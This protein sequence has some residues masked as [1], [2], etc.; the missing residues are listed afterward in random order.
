MVI[1]AA[2]LVPRGREPAAGMALIDGQMAGWMK[3]T[4]GAR[5]RFDV[6]PLR[7][8]GPAD[9]DALEAAAARYGAFLGLEHELQH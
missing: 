6:T 7:P 9:L 2:G 3:R 8:F 4:V 5:V 1:D